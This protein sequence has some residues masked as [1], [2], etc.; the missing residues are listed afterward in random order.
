MPAAVGM[1]RDVGHDFSSGQYG[2]AGAPWQGRLDVEHAFGLAGRGKQNGAGSARR[3]QIP[4]Q[5]FP[6]P[7]VATFDGNLVPTAL[8]GAGLREGLPFAERQGGMFD[9]PGRGSAAVAEADFDIQPVEPLRAGLPGFGDEL[10]EVH[11]ARQ[12]LGAA[13]HMDEVVA[14]DE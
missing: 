1:R 4:V 7:F 8:D 14:G 5:N 13:P 6:A 3:V 9:A 10:A 2:F 12:W 11:C